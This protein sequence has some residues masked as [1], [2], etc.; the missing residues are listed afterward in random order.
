MSRYLLEAADSNH[1]VVVGWDNQLQTYFVQVLDA[2]CE[3]DEPPVLWA[4]CCRG[5][6]PSVDAL[7]DL[8][9][10]YAVIPQDTRTQ[11]QQD[12]EMRRPPKV[13]E[14]LGDLAAAL[15]QAARRKVR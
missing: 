12:Y 14:G 15:D 5:E 10:P 13:P 1:K 8:V 2:D 11:L 7:V 6:I 3:C 4:G 9:R